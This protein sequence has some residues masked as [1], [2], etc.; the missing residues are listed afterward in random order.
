MTDPRLFPVICELQID[1]VWVD[2]TQRLRK[3][4]GPVSI[5][6]GSEDE[7]SRAQPTTTDV[8]LDNKDGF[9]TPDNPQSPWWPHIGRGTPVRISMPG[10]VS[11]LV[12]DGAIANHASTPD[13]ASL[14]IVGDLWLAAEVALDDWHDFGAALNQTLIGKW[15]PTGNQR[16]YTLRKL[17]GFLILSWSPDG[18]SANALSESCAITPVS[19]DGRMAVAAHID[20]NN[21]AGG[22]TTTLYTAPRLEGPWTT[23]DEVV[24]A[25]TTSIFSSSAA[26]KIGPQ[27]PGFGIV[28]APF[29][30]RGYR[31]EVRSGDMT[32][33]VAANPDFT[34]RT[35]GTTSFVDTSAVPKTWTLQGAATIG[36]RHI[37]FS[38]T[39]DAVALS[40]PQPRQRSS[41]LP[42]VAHAKITASGDLR[43]MVQGAK[44][45]NS[46][47]RRLVGSPSVADNV[48]AYWPLEDGSDAASAA[49]PIPGV[50]PMNL[51]GGDWR[52]ASDSSLVASG[53]LP[54][55]SG[56]ATYGHNGII[57]AASGTQWR[58]DMFVFMETP[59]VE[60]AR[61][62][63]Q[64]IST[65][66]TPVVR[67]AF[68]IS[69]TTVNVTGRDASGT[70]L[71][72]S[73]IPSDPRFF[74]TWV[75]WSLN[76]EQDGGN[77]DWALS[78]V[79]I[80]LGLGFGDSGTIAGTVGRVTRIQN[81]YPT[82]PPNGLS[83][84][85][86]VV[87]TG[88]G[89]GWLAGADT[90][91]AGE[92]AAHRFYRLCREERIPMAI[93]GDPTVTQHFRG[94]P[95]RS[96]LM[97]PQRPRNIL[98]LFQE[99]V[100]ADVGMMFERRDNTGLAFRTHQ[101]LHNQAPAVVLDMAQ[102]GLD[103]P[104]EPTLDDQRLRNDVTATRED[105]S[106]ARATTDPPPAPGDLYDEDVTVNVE[107][108]SQLEQ[109][110][111]WRLHLG[112]W[113]DLRYPGLSS[114]MRAAGPAVVAAWSEADL[115]D[116]VRADNLMA[117]HA[118]STE[119]LLQGYTETLDHWHWRVGINGSPAGPWTV[120][121]LD[122]DGTPDTGLARLDTDG[123][124]LAS[125]LTASTGD[126]A[127]PITVTA[128][129]EWTDAA[130]HYPLGLIIGGE[131]M[132]AGSLIDFGGPVFVV[133]RAVNGVLKAHPAGTPVH[134]ADPFRLAL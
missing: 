35:P 18:T 76:I 8:V 114:S 39:A 124:V 55:V 21:G 134:V 32:G 45:L 78:I 74:D 110:A 43:R 125:A 120:G 15:E 119:V 48:I 70:A 37:R 4:G 104:F 75:L 69:D 123:T 5:R 1:R 23:V 28:R 115:G 87:S 20:V 38:G 30:G 121:T 36:D 93:I 86:M 90:A 13:A 129:P 91:W 2:A 126:T 132:T 26:L 71:V 11:H 84:G 61:T 9:L 62:R 67:W 130:G 77:V 24:T 128:G 82:P 133:T 16:S 3:A 14:D 40:W 12:L 108:D 112:T 73:T 117:Q 31:F 19:A 27:D 103:D 29:A 98:D 92:T 56:S 47:L 94:D 118:R 101:T 49:S 85:H 107:A 17:G 34:G 52:F 57:P 127:V 116:K 63:L 51:N 25:G 79:P 42:A 122:T 6:R 50:A 22:R 95:A 72:D 89:L 105:G 46:T 113:P 44:P 59:S 96:E 102:R 41:T 68:S 58:I 131:L 60:P 64:V 106:S 7:A 66:G 99:C 53:A 80:P 33:T 100:D 109:Q 65:T 83:M 10:G 54:S 111:S 81:T 88:L 97:G